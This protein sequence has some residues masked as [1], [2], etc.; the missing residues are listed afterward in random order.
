MARW[1]TPSIGSQAQA[2]ARQWG[3]TF[4]HVNF[5]RTLGMMKNLLKGNEDKSLK[6]YTQDEI[7]GCINWLHGASEAGMLNKPI[8]SPGVLRE[9]LEDYRGGKAVSETWLCWSPPVVTVEM[10]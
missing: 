2:L 6:S 10:L 3:Q 7:S 4:G 1:K 9:V 5:S 8:T